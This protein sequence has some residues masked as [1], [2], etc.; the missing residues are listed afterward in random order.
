M[1]KIIKFLAVP[2]F[3]VSLVLVA[4]TSDS[5]ELKASVIK[6]CGTDSNGEHYCCYYDG[7]KVICRRE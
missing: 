7:G 1:K 3:A 5:N 6:Q 2:F 4:S